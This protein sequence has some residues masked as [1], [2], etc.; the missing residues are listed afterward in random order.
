MGSADR[1]ATLFLFIWKSIRTELSHSSGRIKIRAFQSEVWGYLIWA[2]L[3]TVGTFRGGLKNQ[4]FSTAKRKSA[5][6]NVIMGLEMQPW[7]QPVADRQSCRVFVYK[8][9]HSLST[10]VINADCL[11]SVLAFTCP[12]SLCVQV[13]VGMCNSAGPAVLKQG[14]C[15]AFMS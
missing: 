14:L 9:I 10:L 15:S 12:L 8:N 11:V 13:Y 7:W 4:G 1:E 5:P 2:L 6:Q 3:E